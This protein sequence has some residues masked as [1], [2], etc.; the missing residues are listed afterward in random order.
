MENRA[1]TAEVLKFPSIIRHVLVSL[2]NKEREVY[3]HHSIY[4]IMT[5]LLRSTLEK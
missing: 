5:I 3:S 2:S 4:P 1:S